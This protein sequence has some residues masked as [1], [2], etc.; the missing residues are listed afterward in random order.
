MSSFKQGLMVFFAFFFMICAIGAQKEI[1]SVPPLEE[2]PDLIGQ[3][4]KR[5]RRELPHNL[6]IEILKVRSELSPKDHQN[7]PQS[8][9]IPRTRWAGG[10]VFS[11]ATDPSGNK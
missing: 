8:W 6:A 1:L 3:S 5:A 11:R 7:D 9:S 4:L 2:M 10:F